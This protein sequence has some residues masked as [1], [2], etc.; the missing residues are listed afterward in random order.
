VGILDDDDALESRSVNFRC[1]PDLLERL[2]KLSKATGRKRSRLIV[3]LLSYA[4][5]P[6]EAEL[7]AKRLH[8]K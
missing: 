3:K 6:A 5:S 2:D 4:I 7:A 8:R 1:P